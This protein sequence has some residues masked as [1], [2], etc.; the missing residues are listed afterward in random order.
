MYKYRYRYN[1]T[2]SGGC[3]V[4][5]PTYCTMSLMVTVCAA[6]GRAG[7]AGRRR[8]GIGRMGGRVGGG[9][10]VPP[11]VSRA[12]QCG[13]VC[14]VQCCAER[15]AECSAECSAGYSGGCCVQCCGECSAGCLKPCHETPTLCIRQWSFP[16]LG[17]T[18]HQVILDT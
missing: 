7:C 13:A 10:G 3:L 5:L 9:P 14:S 11:A 4:F 12:F 1:Y 6:C 8:T 2:C 17:K 16:A 15:C 18:L